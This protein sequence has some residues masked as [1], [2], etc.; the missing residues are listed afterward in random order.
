MHALPR[1]TG[2]ANTPRCVGLTRGNPGRTEGVPDGT[3]EGM[4]DG[5]PEGTPDGTPEGM[6]DGIPEGTPD[7]TP[8]EDA[9]R[10]PGGH[11]GPWYP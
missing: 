7:G 4:P 10:Y 1:A 2:H 11:A 3:P 8:E 5:I 6:P 9:R